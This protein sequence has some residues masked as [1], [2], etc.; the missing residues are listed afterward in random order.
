[1]AVA[2]ISSPLPRYNNM[3]LSTSALD[4]FSMSFFAEV[5]DEFTVESV[6]EPSRKVG[7][8]EHIEVIPSTSPL[9]LIENSQLCDIWYDIFELDD[10]RTE[11]RELCRAMRTHCT[12]GPDAKVCT[13]SQSYHTRGLEQRSCLERQ[14]RKYLT[15]KCVVRGQHGINDERLAELSLRCTRWAAE[16]AQEEGARDFV[17]AYLEPHHDDDDEQGQTAKRGAADEIFDTR[18][19]R[20]RLAFPAEA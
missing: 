8:A 17:H 12:Q 16:L 19:V 15:M 18:R 10:F 9:D 13:F 1:M 5:S 3:P 6:Q 20:P 7:F 14:R 4:S 11:V 2:L